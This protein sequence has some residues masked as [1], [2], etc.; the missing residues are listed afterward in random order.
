MKTKYILILI[1]IIILISCTTIRDIIY[2]PPKEINDFLSAIIIEPEILNNLPERFPELYCKEL[3]HSN[4]ENKELINY[5]IKFIKEK[6]PKR[7]KILYLYHA[8]DKAKTQF[9]GLY[10]DFKGLYWDNSILLKYNEEQLFYT[11]IELDRNNKNVIIMLWIKIS[12]KYYLFDIHCSEKRGL[13]I[14]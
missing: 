1:S 8:Q 13:N 2:S 14:K 5:T 9:K 6:L 4:L 11:R 10:W 12:K 7:S 3:R